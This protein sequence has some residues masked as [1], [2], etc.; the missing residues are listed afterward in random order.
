MKCHSCPHSQAI[1][2]GEY[3]STPWEKLPCATCK[4]G[5]DT[6]FSIPFDEQNPPESSVLHPTS[7][8]QPS[9]NTLLPVDLLSDFVTGLMSLPSEL[10]DVVAWRFQG[11][12]YKEIAERQGTT[13]Q[14][15]EM[16]H[17]RALKIWP[18]LQSLFP[19]KAAKR[20]RRLS[21]QEGCA[22]PLTALSPN[23]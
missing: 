13:T 2:S 1:R 6:F 9:T 11:L 19:R 18:A 14:C 12:Q 7:H 22:R 16:R 23:N 4:L 5:E 17:K 21:R 3:A 8:I 15:A 10:R 20:R